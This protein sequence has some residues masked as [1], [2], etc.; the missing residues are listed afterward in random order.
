MKAEILTPW[1]GDG[2]T[3]DTANRPKVMDDYAVQRCTDTTGQPVAN[4]HPNPN[5]L[6]VQ[7]ECDQATLDAIKADNQY[8]VLWH[9]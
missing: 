5:M 8:Q 6:I 4:L 3:V 2:L 9:E 1:V 7:I